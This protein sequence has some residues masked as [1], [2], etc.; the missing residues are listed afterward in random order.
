MF[1]TADT[2]L[3]FVFWSDWGCVS[4]MDAADCPVSDAASFAVSWKAGA[5][6]SWVCTNRM[7]VRVCTSAKAIEGG[8]VVA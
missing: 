4:G 5:T 3:G 8:A 6:H 7:L 1:F 2:F